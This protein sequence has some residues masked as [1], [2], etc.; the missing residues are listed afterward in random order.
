M[1]PAAAT[2]VR[3]IRTADTSNPLGR[4]LRRLLSALDRLLPAGAPGNDTPLPPEWFRL[5]PF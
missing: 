4:S 2:L 3:D 1:T 5:P